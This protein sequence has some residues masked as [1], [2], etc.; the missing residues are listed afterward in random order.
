MRRAIPLK[1]D[2]AFLRV[3]LLLLRYILYITVFSLG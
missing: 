2:R 3:F 1:S